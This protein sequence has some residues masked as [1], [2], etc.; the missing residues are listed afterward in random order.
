MQH[1]P[2][3][4]RRRAERAPLPF[5]PYK[6]F[7][8][9]T[10]GAPLQ[11]VP[12]DLGL[13]CPHRRPGGAGGCTFCPADGARAK[14]TQEPGGDSL[15]EQIRR[16]LAFARRRYRAARFMAYLQAYTA[17][18]APP[19]RQRALFERVLAA[20]P[21]DALS[22]ATRPDC[23]PPA[24]LDLLA[25]LRNR[26]DVWVELGVQTVH[27]PTLARVNRGHDWAASRRAILALHDRG[28]RVA[29]H[30]ILGLPGET[31][32]H[33]ARTADT[34][35]A[36]PLSGIKIHNL[37]V[38]R[39]TALEREFRATPFPVYDA[40]AY[41]DILIEFLARLPPDLPIMRLNTDTPAAELVA[42]RWTLAK[43]QFRQYLIAEMN[44][45]G[46]RQGSL[47]ASPANTA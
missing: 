34:L 36:L 7:L 15:E 1:E 38:V 4:R 42:P 20:Y 23:L 31:A 22:I 39:D 32:A 33:F 5:Y 29:A 28:L 26:L 35:A 40:Y 24:T 18:F 41:A 47:L 19:A 37:H 25:G 14:H 10:Y 43:G 46:R 12:I 30:V 8:I 9:E 16:G 17:T 6:Q 27:D 3:P 44:R 13:G 11:R 45:R 2:T 21:F